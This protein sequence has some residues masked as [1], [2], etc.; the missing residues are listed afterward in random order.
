MITEQAVDKVLKVR[1]QLF[2]SVYGML[3]NIDVVD[4]EAADEITDKLMEEFIIT[5]RS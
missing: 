4:C 2:E 5:T 3:R 1:E